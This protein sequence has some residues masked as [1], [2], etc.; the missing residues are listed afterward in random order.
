MVIGIFFHICFVRSWIM[1]FRVFIKLG[2]N[3]K[4]LQI[5]QAICS[6]NFARGVNLWHGH[7]KSTSSPYFFLITPSLSFPTALSYSLI[8]GAPFR[9]IV[10]IIILVSSIWY[11]NSWKITFCKVKPGQR[12]FLLGE[13]KIIEVFKTRAFS[14]TNNSKYDLAPHDR[15]RFRKI[16][17]YCISLI[18]N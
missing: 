15:Q 5:G 2:L 1:S 9:K 10:V 17:W 11:E 12:S 8:S 4:G 3:G 16:M 6:R 13:N 14:V 18:N 7:P